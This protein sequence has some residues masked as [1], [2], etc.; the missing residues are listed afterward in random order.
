MIANTPAAW[1]QRADA[2]TSHEACLWSRDGQTGRFQTVLGA[3]H[4]QPGETFLDYGCGTGALCEHL[5]AGAQYVGYDWSGGMLERAKR[6]H[7][8]RDFIGYTPIGPYDLVAAIGPFNLP[9]NWSKYRTRETI[10]KLWRSTGRALA[11][12][13]YAG[14]DPD[15]L[16]YTEDDLA[17][18]AAGLETSRVLVVR[19]RPND[20]LLLLER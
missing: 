16:R 20:L 2:A 13:L 10:R 11:A 4:P 6:E 9:D 19:H 7:P 17:E 5:P 1:S 18:I 15:C 14:D 3:L 12:C 8:Y